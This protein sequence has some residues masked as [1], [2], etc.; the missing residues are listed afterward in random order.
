MRDGTFP[1]ISLSAYAEILEGGK[2][3][4]RIISQEF[5]GAKLAKRLPS[6]CIRTE[7]FPGLHSS[8][9]ALAESGLPGLLDTK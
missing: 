1:T 3:R 9:S 4:S 5:C 8:T 7:G 2:K 6:A